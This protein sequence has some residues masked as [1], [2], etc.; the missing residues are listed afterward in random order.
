MGENLRNPSR[1]FGAPP[2]YHEVMGTA[3][4][5]DFNP[6]STTPLS[7]DTVFPLQPFECS[8]GDILEA[9]CD[10]TSCESHLGDVTYRI[11]DE[12]T[13]LTYIGNGDFIFVQKRNSVAG[14]IPANHLRP[15]PATRSGVPLSASQVVNSSNTDDSAL[16]ADLEVHLRYKA[17]YHGEINRK[18]AEDRLLHSR[19]TQ[20]GLYLVRAGELVPRREL[21]L[22]VVTGT[23]SVDHYKIRYCRDAS[24][25]IMFFFEDS[26][27][28]F[29]SFESL[30]NS[31]RTVSFTLFFF[32]LLF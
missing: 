10:S 12:F 15:K 21:I 13:F 25:S 26:F 24:R 30:L 3:P 23:N 4:P 9:I 29:N 22:S 14:V 8:Q 19:L 2:P 6:Q 7:T 31:T 17:W 32:I 18:E 1:A 16:L 28:K 27:D 5:E 20:L 11:G